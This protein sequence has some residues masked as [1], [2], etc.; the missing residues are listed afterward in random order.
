MSD[1][2][3]YFSFGEGSERWAA[4]NPRRCSQSGMAEAYGYLVALCPDTKTAVAKLRQ[5]R[6]R[7]RAGTP[8]ER[9]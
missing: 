8:K 5:I 7:Y 6:A 3:H 9:P 1:E 2:P 4:P